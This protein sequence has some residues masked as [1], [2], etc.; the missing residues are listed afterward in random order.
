MIRTASGGA[1]HNQVQHKQ[2]QHKQVEHEVELEFSP[3]DA[4]P[5]RESPERT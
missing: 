4:I 5:V 3:G 1:M 2:A